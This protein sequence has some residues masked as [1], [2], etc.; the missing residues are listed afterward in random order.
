MA[1]IDH[2]LAHW[3]DKFRRDSTCP[4]CNTDPYELF[5]L[6]TLFGL[7]KHGTKYIDEETA[8]D[9]SSESGG[10]N[11]DG[12]DDDDERDDHEA[13]SDAS[14][15]DAESGDDDDDDDIDPRLIA[16]SFRCDD[17]QE[18]PRTKSSGQVPRQ[19]HL[20]NYGPNR[21][22]LRIVSMDQFGAQPWA[23]RHF[24]V[25]PRCGYR[26]DGKDPDQNSRYHQDIARAVNVAREQIGALMEVM[27]LP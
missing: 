24:N 15:G 25:C 13:R 7:K 18:P 14:M 9:T 17:T 26:F 2:I 5:L 22:V 10:E 3:C 4:T 19:P 8:S 21:Y 23:K 12:S 6:T 16:A 20:H 27:E 1:E 11:R